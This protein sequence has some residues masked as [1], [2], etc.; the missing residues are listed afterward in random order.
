MGLENDSVLHLPFKDPNNQE[1]RYHTIFPA[2]P[3]QE[4]NFGALY[5][6]DNGPW[7]T[8]NMD[9]AQQLPKGAPSSFATALSSHSETVV[10]SSR[11]RVPLPSV[12]QRTAQAC[13]KCRERKTK[14]YASSCSGLRHYSQYLVCSAQVIAP[15]VFDVRTAALYANILHDYGYPHDRGFILPVISNQ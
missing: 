5:L 2:M 13:N 4:S 6:P 14:V 9:M 1:N 11:A 12:R 7:I 8:Q 3:S 15:F 10:N